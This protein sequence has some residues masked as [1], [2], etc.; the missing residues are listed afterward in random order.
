V[1]LGLGRDDA[2]TFGHEKDLIGRVHVPAV[3]CAILEVDLR[4]T[5]V[6]AVLTAD[7]RERVDMPREDLGGALR[8]LLTIGSQHPHAPIVAHLRQT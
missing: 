1:L 5:K 2:V 6:L 8:P 4:Q 7:G 3:A